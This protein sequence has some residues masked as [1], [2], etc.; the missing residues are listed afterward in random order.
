MP[1]EFPNDTHTHT[2]AHTEKTFETSFGIL[3]KRLSEFLN[4]T[5]DP[6]CNDSICSLI[7]R[8]VAIKKSYLEQY[9]TL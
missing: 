9:G 7:F 2:H 5:E 4:D 1:S 6:R 8:R 3:R